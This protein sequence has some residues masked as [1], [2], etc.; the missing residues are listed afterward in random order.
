MPL[1]D[2]LL[3]DVHAALELLEPCRGSVTLRYDFSIDDERAFR[4]GGKFFQSGD[5]LRKL[6]CLVLVV[7]GYE[8]H[9]IR[10]GVGQHANAVVLRLEGPTLSRYLAADAGVHRLERSRW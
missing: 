5:N 7:P 2:V 10:R 8:L 4:A 1:D 9:V 6:F 3:L